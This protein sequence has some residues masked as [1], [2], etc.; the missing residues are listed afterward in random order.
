MK[1]LV[2]FLAVMSLTISAFASNGNGGKIPSG[3]VKNIIVMISDGCGYNQIDAASIYQ[4]GKTGV[5][6]YEHFPVKMGMSTYSILGNYNPEE[7]WTDFNYVNLNPTDSAAAGTAMSTGVKTYDA[8]IGVDVDQNP[9]K[10]IIEYAEERGM[11]TGVVTS[12]EFSHATPAAFVAH[13]VN[14]N[15]YADIANE[16]IYQSALE[17]IMGCG[18]PDYDNN[19]NPAALNSKYVGGDATFND[20]TSDYKVTGADANKDGDTDD[21]KVIR[22]RADF[23]AM[24]S[25]ETPARVI[26]LPYVYTT[27]QQA[28]SGDGYADPYEVPM[29]EKVPT[30]EEMTKAAL[31]VLDDDEDGLFLMVEGGAVDWAG[32]ANQ[33]GRIIEEEIDFNKSVE[34]VVSWVEKN[35]NWGETLLIVTGDHETGYLNGPDSDPNWMPL[36][37]NGAGILPGMEWHSGNHTNSLIPFFAKGSAARLF[38]KNTEGDDPVRGPYIDNTTCGNVIIDIL[39]N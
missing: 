4:Y 29:I 10:H 39:K 9:L 21:W 27:L 16:M 13:N 28:R 19:G 35:S 26:G 24:A 1:K 6:V 15:N 33:S 18:A 5:Q 11:A 34:A 20:L 23:Q 17:V 3:K 22:S 25:G 37:N 12:V 30:L 32:H 36:E 8:A 2:V 31:N 7:A 14:R 38:K